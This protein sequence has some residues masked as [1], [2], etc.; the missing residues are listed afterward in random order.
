MQETR[1]P[2]APP[3]GATSI[4]II[5]KCAEEIADGNESLG[6]ALRHKEISSI[7][8]IRRQYLESA[9]GEGTVGFYNAAEDILTGA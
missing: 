4:G 2:K 9:R 6:A 5:Q 8:M 7:M 3:P 1:K